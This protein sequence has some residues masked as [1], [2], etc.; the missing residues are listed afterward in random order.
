[1]FLNEKVRWIN[2]SVEVISKEAVILSIS[3][4]EL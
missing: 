3:S 4:K 2:Y 1:M